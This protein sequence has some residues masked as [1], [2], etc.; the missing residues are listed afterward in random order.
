VSPAALGATDQAS[1]RNVLA[2]QSNQIQQGILASTGEVRPCAPGEAGM[3]ILEALVLLTAAAILF[4]LA[5]I[6]ASAITQAEPNLLY[7]VFGAVVGF[8]TAASI[9][10]STIDQERARHNAEM[11][12]AEENMKKMRLL[13]NGQDK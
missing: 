2:R 13:F 6:V 8:L 10:Q 5:I 11:D 7:T 3:R 1:C 12:W 4:V 9:Y